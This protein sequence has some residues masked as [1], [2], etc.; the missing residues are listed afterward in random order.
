MVSPAGRCPPSLLYGQTHNPLRLRACPDLTLDLSALND[1]ER[2]LL[3]PSA[4]QEA[5]SRGRNQTRAETPT[6]MRQ[7]S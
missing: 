4:C 7:G 2:H 6:P 3:T 5:T 1:V